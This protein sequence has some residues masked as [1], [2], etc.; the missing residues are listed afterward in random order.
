MSNDLQNVHKPWQAGKLSNITRS[1]PVD[2]A[3]DGTFTDENG[4]FIRAGTTGY[5]RYCPVGNEDSEAIEKEFT[6]SSYFV[7]PEICRKIFGTLAD[8]GQ[9]SMAEDIYIGYGV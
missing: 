1:L 2:P 7:D 4:F 8:G 3:E 5:I 6:A 9:R